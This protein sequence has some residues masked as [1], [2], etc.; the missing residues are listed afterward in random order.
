MNPHGVGAC[1][2]ISQ[3]RI[4]RDW[5]FS[6]VSP[7]LLLK[8]RTNPTKDVFEARTDIPYRDDVQENEYGES[9][10]RMKSRCHLLKFCISSL[11]P[12]RRS[13][14]ADLNQVSV[15]LWVV[16]SLHREQAQGLSFSVGQSFP[17]AFAIT[18]SISFPISLFR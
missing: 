10:H 6:S 12:P 13:R 14:L 17:S 18:A 8:N 16:L 7:S 15:R 3:I 11:I 9:F 4:H 5:A 1:S 2:F